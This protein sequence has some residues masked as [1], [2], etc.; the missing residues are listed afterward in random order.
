MSTPASADSQPLLVD[1][2]K[3]GKYPVRVSERLL[4]S[5]K[6][7]N[8]GYTSVQRKSYIYKCAIVSYSN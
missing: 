4:D 8:Y 3:P 1:P 2:Y 7:A 5:T 6:A